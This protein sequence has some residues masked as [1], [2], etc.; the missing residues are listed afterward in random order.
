MYTTETV[1]V[2]RQDGEL[3]VHRWI[4][5]QQ[6]RAGVVI[7]QEIFG[8]STYIRQRAGDLAREGYVVDIP[9]LYFRLADPVVA[10]D[11][12]DLLARGMELMANTPWEQATGD[13]LAA[14]RRLKSDLPSLA[15]TDRLACVGFCYGG[16]V[17]YAAAANAEAEGS[18][19]IDALVSY[20]GS[21]L[22]TLLNSH[23]RAP[24]LHHFGTADQFI[25]MD[26]VEQIRAH[27]EADGAQFRLYEGAD[28]AFD[29][30]LPT[31]HHSE[32]SQAA[33]EETVS[34]LSSVLT[35]N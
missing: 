34:F 25:P 2:P 20:Y 32:A 18:S 28:H 33:W 35:S 22:P 12:P 7:V 4:P 30:N 23:V 14:A 21:A 5:K 29:N 24:S 10:D 31:F 19:P 1:T 9:E 6:P 17:A 16:G 3:P 13:L 15:A 11:D 26:Q 8:V 27:V